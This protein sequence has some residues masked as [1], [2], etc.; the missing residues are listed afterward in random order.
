MTRSISTS[1]LRQARAHAQQGA[2]LLEVLIAILIMSFG[3]MALAGLAASSQQY[4]KMSQFQ[5]VGSQLAIDFAERMRAN[6]AGF[7]QG[8]YDKTDVYVNSSE[9][10]PMPACALPTQC[11]AQ[12]MAARDQADWLNDLRVRLP[13]GDAFVQ[14]DVFNPLAADVWVMWLDPTLVTGPA[15]GD[16]LSTGSAADCPAAAIGS[17]P[18]GGMPRCL[19]YRVSI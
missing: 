4:S 7:E 2:S 12:E 18:A 1:R 13:G 15:A 14:R 19:Y 5:T 11:T 8:F 9:L 16:N 6:V 3:L 17:V 10:V